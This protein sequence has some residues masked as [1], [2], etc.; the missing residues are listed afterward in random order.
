MQPLT[1][2]GEHVPHAYIDR[3][4]LHALCGTPPLGTAPPVAVGMVGRRA[5]T[6]SYIGAPLNP[7]NGSCA[8]LYSL[9]NEAVP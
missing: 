8:L 1:A 5:L 2:K 7:L 4:D 9:Y 3:V 6:S